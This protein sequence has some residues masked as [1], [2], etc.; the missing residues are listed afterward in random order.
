MTDK[1]QK[2]TKVKCKR[3]ESRKNR[4]NWWNIF[5]PRRSTWV[6]LEL[7]RRWTQHF[8]KNRPGEMENWANL[9]VRPHDYRICYINID[10]R[11]QYGI[12]VAMSQTFLR[13]KRSQRLIAR[14]NGCF[15]RL[16]TGYLSIYAPSN[17]WMCFLSFWCRLFM[18]KCWNLFLQRLRWEKRK[19]NLKTIF[20]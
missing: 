15:R 19:W 4:Q 6:L 17:L 5:F 8:S 9:D 1:R 16:R 3:D 13:A 2:A 7:V 11:H 10:L 20:P 18:A 14:R 12:S